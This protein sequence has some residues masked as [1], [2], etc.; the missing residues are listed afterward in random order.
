M[1]ACILCLC[2]ALLCGSA[3]GQ[4]VPATGADVAALSS[5]GTVRWLSEQLRRE[6][7][8]GGGLRRTL[9]SAETVVEGTV[10]RMMEVCFVHCSAVVC[11]RSLPDPDR[12]RTRGCRQ[13]L[14]LLSV[15]V[16][17]SVSVPATVPATVGDPASL[18]T[19]DHFDEGQHFSFLQLA[20]DDDAQYPLDVP[21]YDNPLK[22]GDR[23]RL[24]LRQ[25]S[26]WKVREGQQAMPQQFAVLAVFDPETPEPATR[27][28]QVTAVPNSPGRRTLLAMAI[29][30]V[31]APPVCDVA[32]IKVRQR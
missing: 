12:Q 10:Q 32:C 16:S 19:Q 3:L 26:K 23:A 17:V 30:M 24:L 15:S 5:L 8:R 6:V 4:L 20:T 25:E 14:Q 1:G 18:W 29:S 22:A 11:S 27:R 13:R 28:M 7:L 2:L 9:R 31:D 21:A